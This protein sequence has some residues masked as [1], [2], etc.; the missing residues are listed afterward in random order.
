MRGRTRGEVHD[1]GSG[2]AP[3]DSRVH[4][5]AGIPPGHSI[6]GQGGV[7]VHPPL[8]LIAVAAEVVP[9]RTDLSR[10]ELREDLTEPV[11]AFSDRDVVPDQFPDPEPGAHDLGRA[12]RRFLREVDAWAL[13]SSHGLLEKLLGHVRH[14]PLAP[15]R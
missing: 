3:G 11:L 12:A 4:A 6:R 8:D 1:P 14:G 9:R 10:R 7:L 5:Q 2:D 13:P 15:L